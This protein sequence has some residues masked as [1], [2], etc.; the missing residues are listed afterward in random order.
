MGSFGFSVNPH[1]KLNP[2]IPARLHEIVKIS[3]KYICIGSSDFSPTLNAAV[4]V[5]GV[6]IKSTF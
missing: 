6:T 2:Q 5:V 1:G 3:D 4:G